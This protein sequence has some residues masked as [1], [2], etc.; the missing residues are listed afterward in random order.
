VVATLFRAGEPAGVLFDA[1]TDPVFCAAVLRTIAGN[2]HYSFEGGDLIATHYPLFEEARGPDE[3]PEPIVVQQG[4]RRHV[5]T[6]YGDRL[7]LKAFDRLEPGPNPA[8]ELGRF[9]TDHTAFDA[10]AP[11]VGAVEVRLPDEDSITLSV[12][13][14]HVPNEGNAWDYTL[15]VISRFYEAVLARPGAPPA[16]APADAWTPGAVPPPPA[17]AED[18][19]GPYLQTAGQ[20][21]RTTAEMHRALGSATSPGIAPEPFG[22]LYQRS[23]YQSMRT[24]T[25]LVFRDLARRL[26][27]LPP[28]AAGLAAVALEREPVLLRRHRV[29]LGA[30]ITGYRIRCHGDYHLGQLLY[31]GTDFRV[32]DF[33]GDPDRPLSERRI[34]RSPLRDVADMIRSFHYA[35]YSPLYAAEPGQGTFPGRV[36][37]ADRDVL[38]GWARFWSSWVAAEFVRAYFAGMDGANLLPARPDVCRDLLELF[39]LEKAVKELGGDLATRPDRLPIPLTGLIDLTGTEGP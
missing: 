39:V 27:D 4:T 25:K 16:P 6:N 32:I 31:A 11:V 30:D 20:L 34:K 14:G 1:R 33:E 37:E 22:R 3:V 24:A 38:M 23:L 2:R 8:L 17:E 29:V 28:E 26:P 7:I 21:G 35:A 12:L 9:L 15:D 5:S 36:R 19:I 13:F 18:L 10:T